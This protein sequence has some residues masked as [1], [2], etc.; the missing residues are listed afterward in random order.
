M[1]RCL[2]SNLKEIIIPVFSM[3][4][5]V[6][7]VTG[8]DKKTVKQEQV[9]TSEE[10][11]PIAVVNGE[12]I[13]QRHIDVSMT[14]NFTQVEQLVMNDAVQEKILQSL[15]ASRALADMASKHLEADVKANINIQ[16]QLY[17]EEL[18][19]RAY[20]EAFTSSEPV[21]DKQVLDY[22]QKN[23]ALFGQ[24]DLY[25]AK[26]LLVDENIPAKDLPNVLKSHHR[27]WASLAK[28][29]YIEFSEQN[30]AL[31]TLSPALAIVLKQ[32]KV[33]E[34]SNAV[35]ENG[36]THLFFLQEAIVQPAKPLVQV[37]SDIRKKLAGGKIRKQLKA[38]TEKALSESAV[39]YF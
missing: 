30:L 38:L 3:F 2:R 10:G 26:W 21:S 15:V 16:T 12:S 36:Q 13:H 25:R 28:E 24:V 17:R 14:K 33:G 35:S 22:Y 8:C 9:V 19:L 23:L 39:T 5:V 31:D 27:D 32:T 18:L 7:I 37:S 34:V 4:A 11:A 6:V 20:L 29:R 1:G